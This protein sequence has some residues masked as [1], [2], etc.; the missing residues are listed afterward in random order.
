MTNV[1][2]YFGG[3]PTEPDVRKLMDHFGVPQPGLIAHEVLEQLVG[4][5]HTSSRYVTVVGAWRKKLLREFNVASKA[6]PGDGIK[7]L[8]EPERV[9]ES[10]RRLGQ[11]AR[12]AARDHRWALM[13]DASKLDDVARKKLDHTLRATAAVATAAAVNIKELA[14]ALKAPA[15]L[16]RKA[17]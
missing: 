6:E 1:K 2:V 10:R 16:P 13:I 5:E 11:S 15:Q 12:Q 14:T 8:T 4:H 3:I 9:E 17:S 7:I